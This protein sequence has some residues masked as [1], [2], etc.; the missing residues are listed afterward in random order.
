MATPYSLV[1][2]DVT[3]ST[4]DE[5]RRLYEDHPV[6]VVAGSQRQGRGR[7]GRP[8]VNAPRALAASLRIDSDWPTGRVS[9]VPLLAGVAAA[10]A[11]PV[12]LKWPNDLMTA[13]G[14]VGG[15]LSE[16]DGST[17][18]V[19]MGMNLWWPDPPAGMTALYA[20]DPGGDEGVAIANRWAVHL[21]DLIEDGPGEWPRQ[22]YAERCLTIGEEITWTPDGRGVAVG[23][24]E[25][26]GLVVSL[27]SAGRVV[28]RSGEVSHVRNV[29]G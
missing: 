18:T 4:Q 17:V 10:R 21:I 20:N 26:G 12:D 28:I 7:S 11:V 6:L 22:E 9:L 15:I 24:D 13:G 1:T 25:E 16:A 29:G 27:G 8:W 19:G 2:L 14:K 5:A 23:V 3:D